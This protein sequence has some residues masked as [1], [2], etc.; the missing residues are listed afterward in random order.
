MTSAAPEP[1]DRSRVRI[2]Y[3]ALVGG[4]TAVMAVFAGLFW[5]KTAPMLPRDSPPVIA[6]VMGALGIASLLFGWVW[7]RPS[8]PLRASG[9]APASLWR[10]PNAGG[11]A[12][13]LWVLWEG[14]AMIG[15]VGTLLTGS[16]F[17]AGVALAGLALL[18]THSPGFLESRE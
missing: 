9:A 13:L 8:V 12:V 18:L 3:W 4:L 11:R 17:T 7:A 10:D 1:L 2:L 5:L 6:W 16:H 14:G 15:N